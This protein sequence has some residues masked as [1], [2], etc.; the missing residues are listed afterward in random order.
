MNRTFLQIRKLLMTGLC[1]CL[2]IGNILFPSN[3]A[4]AAIPEEVGLP[5][6]EYDTPVLNGLIQPPA[7]KK[8][9]SKNYS[10]YAGQAQ[11]APGFPQQV[12]WGDTHLHTVYSFDAGAAGTTLTPE[13]SYRFARGE[14]VET[15]GGELAQLSRPL[16][17]LVVSDHTD[18]LGSFQQLTTQ[19]PPD[20]CGEDQ[21]QVDEWYYRIENGNDEERAQVKNEITYVFGQ[22]EAPEC[23]LQTQEQ[24]RTAWEEEVDFA[25]AFND[26]YK[27]TALIG[28]EWTA[29]DAGD[30]LHRN[31]IYR[32]NGDKAKQ[33]LP[34]T[35]ED[36]PDPELLWKW[37]AT[38][39]DKT[40]GDVLA[41]PH[42]GNMSN[43]QMFANVDA[44]GL[45]LSHSY[46]E[47]RQRWEPL[48][49][50]T[51]TKGTSETHPKLSPDDEFAS[52]ETAGWDA[53]NLHMSDPKTDDMY[54]Y[55][56]ARAALKNGLKFEDKLGANPFKF[57]LIGSTD[58]HAAISAVEENSN[59]GELP[60][61][62]PSPNRVTNIKK[63][64]SF[65]D[66]DTGETLKRFGWQLGA[67]GYV[68]VWAEANT[69]ESLFDAMARRE[70]YATSGPRM[71]VRLFGGWDF[72]D[73]DLDRNP[74]DVGYAKGVPMGSDLP[75]PQELD[76]NLLEKITQKTNKIAQKTEKIAQKAE[77]IAQKTDKAE[78]IAQKAEK[79]AQKAEKIAQKTDTLADT[80]N[81]YYQKV[82]PPTFLVAALKDPL[83]GNLDR[84]QII[85]GWLDAEGDTHEKVYN[86]AWSDRP[87]D[88]PDSLSPVGNTVNTDTATWENTIG[89][90]ELA[91][92][93]HDPDFE[94]TQ[95]AFY[96]A[97][98]LE[99]PTPRWTD[100]D[101]AF[102]GDEWC[103]EAK[104]EDPTACD[105][106][107]LTLQERVYTSPIWYSPAKTL[108]FPSGPSKPVENVT[109][110]YF[111]D[112][113]IQ[114]VDQ[115]Y[116]TKYMN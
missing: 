34:K 79:I 13:D 47:Q 69:R 106:I 68:G 58:Y 9:T 7:F 105:D 18:Q 115:H 41:I 32:D 4:L 76:L 63:E 3:S 5:A 103:A 110:E 112:T 16:D 39:K 8:T 37:M 38:Y 86:V 98:V 1:I 43:G 6:G 24:F 94:P 62:T 81:Y 46:A 65:V 64:S 30:N 2:L 102:F 109:Q 107:P 77:K 25:E 96:Y 97:R 88:T 104:A 90:V 87:D 31:V 14:Q 35:T 89:A 19:D 101:K 93:W 23:M 21:A 12:F 48:Y 85:K 27:F 113:I 11:A 54:E 95:P 45:P 100:Y 15:D 61:N 116:S 59:M 60:Y 75:S 26:P 50:V 70:V 20:N 66:D 84:I 114:E 10:P 36:G 74:G 83:R 33:L 28:Y 108:E 71:I 56:Y 51:Q 17:F 72:T 91:T 73:A 22:G 82:N 40:C 99:I 92:V 67:A 29:L 111:W 49:E 80:L 52:F 42:N 57:G 44:R 55:E 78:K 53:A